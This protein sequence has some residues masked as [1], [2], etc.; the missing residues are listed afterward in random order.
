[1]SSTM[2]SENRKLALA[3]ALLAFVLVD[4]EG[5]PMCTV[6]EVYAGLFDEHSGPLSEMVLLGNFAVRTR[7]PVEIDPDN[8]DV[9]TDGIPEEY[10]RPTYR[11]GWSL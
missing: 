9:L 3:T 5:G 1:M 11:D 8:G 6:D 2:R 7:G 4:D 10:F